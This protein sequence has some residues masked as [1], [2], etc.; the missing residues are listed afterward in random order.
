MSHLRF[1]LLI[2]SSITHNS[3]NY[4]PKFQNC[5]EDCLHKWWTATIPNSISGTM[6]YASDDRII[7]NIHT[8]YFIEYISIILF[9]FFFSALTTK[10]KYFQ[11]EE[12]IKGLIQ[13]PLKLKRLSFEFGNLWSG[14]KTLLSKNAVCINLLHG[15]LYRVKMN[16]KKDILLFHKATP[17][18]NTWEN[19]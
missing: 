11:M 17:S 3:E 19:C 1:L 13:W 15:S 14:C 9:F 7:L 2:L 4:V 16:I 12:V 6:N 10:I 5:R 8:I 18:L